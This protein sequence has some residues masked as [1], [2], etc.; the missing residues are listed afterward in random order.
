MNDER[1]LAALTFP[2]AGESL[3]KNAVALIP[4]GATEP[5]G[6]HLPLGTDVIISVEAARRAAARLA[7]RSIET[8]VL[9]AMVTN[10]SIAADA[11]AI[12]ARP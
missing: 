5:H 1:D 2:E 9:P 6:P 8:L 7:T 10:Q 12:A 11:T 3:A 4:I